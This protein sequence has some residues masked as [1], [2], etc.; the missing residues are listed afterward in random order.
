MALTTYRHGTVLVA[1]GHWAVVIVTGAAGQV[2]FDLAWRTAVSRDA[3]NLSNEKRVLSSSAVIA[4]AA[5]LKMSYV[6][7]KRLQLPACNHTF[8]IAA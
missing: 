7:R 8:G 2:L 3:G 5:Q 6:K 4:V 1:K